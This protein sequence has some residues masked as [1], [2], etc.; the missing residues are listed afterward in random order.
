MFKP[1]NANTIISAPNFNSQLSCKFLDE[2][3]EAVSDDIIAQQSEQPSCTFAP[4]TIRCPRISWFRLRGALVEPESNVDLSTNFTA[5][6]GTACHRI[7]QTNLSVQLGD[8]WLDVEQY[9]RSMDFD[10]EYT[11]YKNDMETLIEI[12]SPPV[13]FAPDGII[14]YQDR[15]RLLEIKTCDHSGFDQLS[16]PKPIHLDQVK[17]YCTLLDID[18]VIM[19]YQDRQYGGIKCFEVTVSEFDKQSIRDMFNSVLTKVSENLPP[20]KLPTGDKW[21]NATYCRYYNKCKE[22]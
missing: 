3:I 21:C 18:S 6:I 15:I 7:I 4:S 12:K 22:W 1:I 2:Y 10:Y 14:R 20:P 17:C 8:D 11:C 9:M 13:K 16:G 5:Q 19:L